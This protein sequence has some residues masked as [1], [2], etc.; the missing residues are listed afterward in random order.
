VLFETMVKVAAQMLASTHETTFVRRGGSSNIDERCKQVHTRIASSKW[1]AVDSLTPRL[2][3]GSKS[4]V[5]SVAR[6]DGGGGRVCGVMCVVGGAG[7][8]VL[9]VSNGMAAIGSCACGALVL[10]LAGG[11]ADGENGSGVDI[12]WPIWSKGV[13][14][15]LAPVL[16]LQI[17]RT[18]QQINQHSD[19]GESGESGET[20]SK[21]RSS[22]GSIISINF[23]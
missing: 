6:V 15:M 21:A 4:S 12:A 11:M 18:K 23:S 3:R 19:A 9:W 14:L 16:L 13:P 8:G 5:E 7:A 17:T 2:S 22:C 10:G 1:V 20:Y